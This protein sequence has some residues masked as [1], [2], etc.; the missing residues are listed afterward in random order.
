MAAEQ[1]LM[2]ENMNIAW[3]GFVP[4]DWMKSVNTRD[5]IQ[6]NYTPYN[7]DDKFLS[8]VSAK[9]KQLWE[10]LSELIKKET[11]KGVLDAD[12]EV[13]S[14]IVSHG[15][16]YINKELE[17]IVG[18]Q[19]DAPLKRALPRKRNRTGRGNCRTPWDSGAESARNA[20]RLP[21]ENQQTQMPA[22]P[23]CRRRRGREG[24]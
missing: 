9:T 16:G 15:P 11:E 8:G 7:G 10:E 17:V 24:W 13:V 1:D 20:V 5:F 19:T 6:K 3:E 14:S 22:C 12:E 2:K 23:W 4:G 18:L 21:P